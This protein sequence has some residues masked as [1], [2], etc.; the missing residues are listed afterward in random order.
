[1]TKL[2][3]ALQTC[4]KQCDKLGI[5]YGS[6][7][8]ISPSKRAQK[9]WGTC[10][11]TPFGSR[12]VINRELLKKGVSEKALLDTVMHEL[13][14]TC[15]GCADHQETWKRYAAMVNAA[16]GYDV[17][18]CT[19]PEEKGIKPTLENVRYRF[20]CT[21]CGSIVE[22]TRASAFTK[23]P[24]GYRCGKCGGTFE[25]LPVPEKK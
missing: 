16:Y 19:S 22:R 6:V 14:H 11:V 3:K 18:R 8:D 5:P 21:A 23:N 7:F 9:R 10:F 17:K 12:I 15:P 25:R 4:Q 13:L 1:M 20:R 24:A 2:E